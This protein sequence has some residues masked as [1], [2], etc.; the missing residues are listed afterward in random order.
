MKMIDIPE[1]MANAGRDF[2]ETGGEDIL[3]G[4]QARNL[5]DQPAPPQMPGLPQIHNLPTN[6]LLPKQGDIQNNFSTSQQYSARFGVSQN[7]F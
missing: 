7:H 5:L 2:V 6:T 1:E 4:P 3:F